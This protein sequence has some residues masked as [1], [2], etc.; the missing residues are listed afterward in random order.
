MTTVGI[1]SDT[2]GLLRPQAIEA[3]RGVD[4][5][6]HAGDIGGEEIVSR[7]ARVAPVVAIRG[8]I[9]R[10]DWAAALP[11]VQ[12]IE[13]EGRRL[14]VVHD[15]NELGFD[16]AAEGVD[17][18]ISGHSHKPRIVRSKG[19]LYV[20]PGSA[21]P[22]RFRLPIALARLELGPDGASA[23]IHELDLGP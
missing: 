7:L 15:L 3:L 21:G 9:D 10:A 2:H 6:V 13:V 20:N 1:I 22:R 5:I 23:A 18:V 4:L 19:V 8:N 12:D 16:A 17:V 14:Y 11:S